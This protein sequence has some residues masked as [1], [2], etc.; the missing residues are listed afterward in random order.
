MVL[1]SLLLYVTCLEVFKL[2]ALIYYYRFVS[3]N[4]GS[5]PPAYFCSPIDPHL[6][7]LMWSNFSSVLLG[8]FLYPRLCASGGVCYDYTYS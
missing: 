2:S 7:F 3:E 6:V 1:G 5:S 8:H 4:A